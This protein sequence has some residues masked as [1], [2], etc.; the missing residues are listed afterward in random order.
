MNDT[1]ATPPP[2]RLPWW[3]S[4]WLLELLIVLVL[5]AG[6]QFWRTRAVP[7]GP[8]PQFAG[9]LTDGS[10]FDLAAWR[11][12]HP[13]QAQLIYFWADWCTVCKTTAGNV[14]AVAGDHPVI[15]IA[16]QSGDRAQVDATLQAAGYR[17]PTLP[18][19][20]ARLLRDYGLPGVPAFVVIDPQGQIAYTSLGYTSESGL[21]L[22]LWRA[23]Q[24]QENP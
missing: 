12:A 16:I 15:S 5:L 1:G 19:P 24:N 11:K 7:G 9:T 14:T 22:R 4:G 2:A 6:F 3:K 13:G 10:A 20:Q 8:A 18:D 21:R 17:W 23:G